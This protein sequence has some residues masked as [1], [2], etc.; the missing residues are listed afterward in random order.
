VSPATR[1]SPW[2]T[3][4]LNIGYKFVQT[5]GPLKGVRITFNASNLFDRDPPFVAYITGQYTNG[6]DPENAS[7][8]GRV[9]SLQLT[10]AW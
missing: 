2:T 7:P 3:V 8:L 6:Y 5:S 4:D 9:V 1:V 10:K